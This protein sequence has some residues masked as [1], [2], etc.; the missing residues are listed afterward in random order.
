MQLPPSENVQVH[1]QRCKPDRV[2]GE[3]HPGMGIIGFGV[4]PVAGVLLSNGSTGSGRNG[5]QPRR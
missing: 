1:S 4:E 5:E 2:F 3:I